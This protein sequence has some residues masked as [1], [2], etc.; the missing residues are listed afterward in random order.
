MERE[1]ALLCAHLSTLNS[2]EAE[3]VDK[4]AGRGAELRREGR[5]KVSFCASAHHR[6]PAVRGDSSHASA[7]KQFGHDAL[8][9]LLIDLQV[10]CACYVRLTLS[11]RV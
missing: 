9:P 1:R 10:C 6:C 11:R 7:T 5:G 3:G 4:G 2:M 8:D